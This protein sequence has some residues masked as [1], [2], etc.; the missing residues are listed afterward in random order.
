MFPKIVGFTPKSSILIGFSTINHPFWDT[1]I[2]G[3]I[4]LDSFILL[5]FSHAFPFVFLCVSF[6]GFFF[7]SKLVV[8]RYVG[9]GSSYTSGYRLYST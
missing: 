3:N 1:P 5:E 4:H 9:P 7:V 6:L 8:I 2:F